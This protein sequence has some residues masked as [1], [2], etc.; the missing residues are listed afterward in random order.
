MDCACSYRRTRASACILLACTTSLDCILAYHRDT[1][2]SRTTYPPVDLLYI[3]LMFCQSDMASF[4]LS[5]SGGLVHDLISTEVPWRRR[6]DLVKN[7]EST[8]KGMPKRGSRHAEG[9]RYPL[10]GAHDDSSH[11]S[12]EPPP[13]PIDTRSISRPLNEIPAEQTSKM[14]VTNEELNS[15]IQRQV[16]NLASRLRRRLVIPLLHRAAK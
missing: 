8:T 12:H 1:F 15:S 5:M 10:R 9:N 7:S 14:H 4:A 13:L 11:T 6:L 16:E 3:L 2:Q